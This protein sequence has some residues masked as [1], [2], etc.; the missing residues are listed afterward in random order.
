MDSEIADS[1][2][3]LSLENYL[4]IYPDD[5][6]TAQIYWALAEYYRKVFDNPYNGKYY[7]EHQ[8]RAHK[9]LE[10]IRQKYPHT[11]LAKEAENFLKEIEKSSL[12]LQIE[13][14][15]L[16][17]QYILFSTEYANMNKV[18][19]SLYRLTDE[20][21]GKM[22]FLRDGAREWIEKMD[23]N[24][25]SYRQWEVEVP[26]PND[27]RKHRV[28]LAIEPLEAG[29]YVLVASPEKNYSRENE[30]LTA[31]M[32][33]VSELTYISHTIDQK[34]SGIVLHR[35]TG[36]PLADVDVRL[37]SREYD[38]SQRRQKITEYAKLK[39]SKE[40][41]FEYSIA[42]NDR[43][44]MF[45][46]LCKKS[47]VLKS[48]TGHYF[49]H[50]SGNTNEKYQKQTFFFTDRAIYRPSQ[51]LYFKGVLIESKDDDKRLAKNVSTTVRL[52]DANYKDVAKMTV[53]TN[54]YG[55]FNGQF[56]LPA[57]GLNGQYSLQGE[58]GTCYFSVEEYKRPTFEITFNPLKDA[59]MLNQ[60]L[61]VS[62]LAKT[63][64][65]AGLGGSKVKYSVM[66]SRTISVRKSMIPVLSASV[67]AHGETTCDENGQFAI[68]FTAHQG[69]ERSLTQNLVYTFTVTAEITDISGE[70]HQNI[71]RIHISEKALNVS[72]D[73][74][75]QMDKTQDPTVRISSTN[76]SNEKMP[77]KGKIQIFRLQNGRLLQEHYYP[78]P[79]TTVY[80]KEEFIKMFPYMPYFEGDKLENRKK[81]LVFEIDYDTEKDSKIILKNLSK[82]ASGDY[83]YT[84]ET[85][86][87]FGNPVKCEEYFTLYSSQSS[88]DVLQKIYYN[89]V[90]A[91]PVEPGQTFSFV[92]GSAV[93]ASVFYELT[94]KKN[95]L[96]YEMISL[97]KEQK[98]IDISIPKAQRENLNLQIW[99]VENNRIYT[100]SK[101]IQ[102]SN[103]DKKV[104][105]TF[106]TFRNTLLP[107]TQENWTLRLMS[108]ER[109]PLQGELLLGMYDASL[110]AFAK[111]D[112]QL[113]LEPNFRTSYSRWK[114][115]FSQYP[116]RSPNL[117]KEKNYSYSNPEIRYDEL[118]FSAP[119]MYLR[120]LRKFSAA[121]STREETATGGTFEE[122]EVEDKVDMEVAESA[123]FQ[124]K[125]PI[126]LDNQS[127]KETLTNNGTSTSSIVP[128]TN[129]NETAFF[130]P[131]LRSDDSGRIS[132]SF[133]VPES[134][135]R[136]KIRGLAHTL[137]LKTGTQE[138][139]ATTQKNV[140]IFPN[141]PRFLREGD[142]IRLQAK[143]VNLSDSA[144]TGKAELRIDKQS[145]SPLVDF[146]ILK[147]QNTSVSWLYQ[148]N[149]TGLLNLEYL[150]SAGLH[151]DGE[152]RMLPVLSNRTM[153]TETKPLFASPKSEYKFSF[154]KFAKPT[155]QTL[156]NYR[157]TLEITTNPIWYAVQALPELSKPDNDD[158]SISLFGAYFANAMAMDIVQRNPEIKEVFNRWKVAQS[159]TLKS[160]LETNQELKSVLLEETPWV[161]EAEDETCQK[162][163][164]ALYFDENNVQNLQ[165][166][167]LVRM[168]K[169]QL[170]NGGFSWCSGG[171][172]DLWSTQYIIHGLQKLHCRNILRDQS[173]MQDILRKAL[174]YCDSRHIDEYLN[175]LENKQTPSPHVSSLDIQYLYLRT[176]FEKE[177]PVLPEMTKVLTCYDS[178]AKTSWKNQSKYLQSVLALYFDMKGEKKYVQEV[179]KNFERLA[180]KSSEMGMYW[181]YDPSWFWYE[182]P[183]ETQS[184]LIETFARLGDTDDVSEMQRWLLSQ[185]RTTRW[186]TPKASLDALYA[187]LLNA[188]NLS[189]NSDVDVFVGEEKIVPARTDAGSGYFKL[190]WSKN[191]M[192]SKQADV[193]LENRGNTM[194]WGGLYWQY[195]ENL[196]QIQ[197]AKTPLEIRKQLFVER[198]TDAGS[199]LESISKNGL[200]I[201]DKV[202]VRIEIRV[203]RNMEY[204]HLKDLRAAAFEPVDVCSCYRYQDGLFYYQE[205]KDASMNFYF[206]HLPKGVYVFEYTLRASQIGEFSNGYTTMQ[207]LYAPEFSSHSQGER[208]VV[209]P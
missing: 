65:G 7:R 148:A 62:G 41:K 58:N 53:R 66:C 183:I 179:M 100:F 52:V 144:I 94:D 93:K 89:F 55:S 137:D 14:E 165:D 83:A 108:N 28:N 158:N 35:K 104:D 59:Y 98:S 149:G 197:T 34:I 91:K 143:I 29:Y 159:E 44:A 16:P 164:I 24:K 191:E 73:I 71:Q 118:R 17:N 92:V 20:D 185:K 30:A 26:N 18:Y 15:V 203:D 22:D 5:T 176:Y 141:A 145:I 110:D 124:T 112:W 173:E 169:M 6:T 202:K 2:F 1:L 40:G 21:L 163:E 189:E 125:E 97:D 10:Q 4:N 85:Q 139:F 186:H 177:Y 130:Y 37:Y 134:L 86:D 19:F 32:F 80:T 126:N 154:E 192:S 31:Q 102:I 96:K 131:H 155:S 113:N 8:I 84:I 136:W 36:K 56:I 11:V 123:I 79:D 188:P 107:N 116:K 127:L 122:V 156:E 184:M 50:S 72:L 128:R 111:Q 12:S 195:L 43:P 140:M 46:E 207:C 182:S 121:Y 146:S 157:L 90:P 99:C 178:V 160:N 166:D 151:T 161:L 115:H 82:W 75:K 168:R 135:T 103:L 51:T 138:W 153:V 147:N 49:G 88:K 9:Y 129:L 114:F 133:T 63:Y 33:G 190:S 39:T 167:L 47:D 38:Y 196:D 13:N 174:K 64:T 48:F 25:P 175:A 45:V 42:K 27:Y 23:F 170:P 69:H 76:L 117:G 95:V 142:S 54:E 198:A 204:V 119:S 187:L 209:E 162:Q 60:E 87:T 201:G 150:A 81:T 70:T 200:K 74:P 68:T 172:G 181:R 171:K 193:R 180:L 206:D 120:T 77:S 57:N 105:I 101:N 152:A 106:E 61:T 132:V 208:V 3:C 67:I 78:T 194:V 199:V 205:A 109:K